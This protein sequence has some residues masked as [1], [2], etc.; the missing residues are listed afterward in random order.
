MSSRGYRTAAEMAEEA[1][2]WERAAKDDAR[3]NRLWSDVNYWKRWVK[4]SA[5]GGS[6]KA[7]PVLVRP[8]EREIKEK[9]D[10]QRREDKLNRT[11]GVFRA[12][13]AQGG[14]RSIFW[15]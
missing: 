1:R 7:K 12:P 10:R 15:S 13:I 4:D 11:K 8:N 9:R 5:F 2:A 3:R 14:A 6:G